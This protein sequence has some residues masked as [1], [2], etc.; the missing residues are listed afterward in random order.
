MMRSHS[1]STFSWRRSGIL[2]ANCFVHATQ[3]IVQ[4]STADPFLQRTLHVLNLGMAMQQ[5]QKRSLLR[6]QAAAPCALPKVV[7][8][9]NLPVPSTS[10]RCTA[11][12]PIA[13]TTFTHVSFARSS[14]RQA[15]IVCM[16]HNTL[17]DYRLTQQPPARIAVFVSG[18]GSNMKAIHAAIKEG[19]INAEISVGA[20]CTTCSMHASCMGMS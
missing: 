12:A 4:R 8:S 16:A 6:Q 7:P 14:R 9:S 11:A 1:H 5:L 19:T 2:N 17:P 15:H 10:N 20:A 3:D 18:G 13:S